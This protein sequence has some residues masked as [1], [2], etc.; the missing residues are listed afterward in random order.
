MSTT[1]DRMSRGYEPRFDLDY[2]PGHEGETF[3]KRIADGLANGTVETKTD[4]QA[5]KT[6]NVYIEWKA[7]SN[8]SDAWELSGIATTEALTWAIVLAPDV[9]LAV[10]TEVLRELVRRT[11]SVPSQRKDCMR[12]SNPTRGIIVPLDKLLLQLMQISYGLT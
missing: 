9:L 7:W 11:W 2:R 5:V 3:A 10:N 8:A 1:D 4:A 6:R 12:G